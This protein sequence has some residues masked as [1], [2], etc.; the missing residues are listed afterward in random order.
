MVMAGKLS[1]RRLLALAGGGAGAATTLALRRTRDVE[2]HERAVL[3]E[4]VGAWAVDVT[5][6]SSPYR[7]VQMI[8]AD[9]T[10]TL[11]MAPSGPS[12]SGGPSRLYAT[13]YGV[14]Q[15]T[16]PQD[17]EFTLQAFSVT[18][19]GAYNGPLTV[20]GQT[21]LSDDAQSFAANYTSTALSA[22]GGL[23]GHNHGTVTGT[24]V[25]I[26]NE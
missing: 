26:S 18:D 21:H 19:S 17:Y 15:R 8:N 7:G 16:G 4:I 12:A 6:T 13:G 10:L 5:S 11:T 24:R 2:A 23:V 22:D 20:N 1:R 3:D 25:N 14:W 9:G